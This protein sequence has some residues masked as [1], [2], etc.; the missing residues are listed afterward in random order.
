KDD[1]PE[2]YLIPPSAGKKVAPV[3]KFSRREQLADLVTQNNPLLA[4]TFVNR[5]WSILMGRGIVHPVD[6]MDSVHPPS[7]PDLLAWLAHD[8]EE[9]GYDVRRLVRMICLTEAY[10]LD[11]RWNGGAKPQP[12][13]LASAIEKPLRSEALLRSTLVAAGA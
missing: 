1:V 11:S 9:N 12:E 2:K 7:H 10:Q 4:R 5:I 3:P 13:L 8:F 6:R